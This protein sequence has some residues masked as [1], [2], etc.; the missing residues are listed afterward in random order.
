MGGHW[1]ETSAV[2]RSCI[3]LRRRTPVVARRV[4]VRGRCI[5]RHCGSTRDRSKIDGFGIVKASARAAST[6]LLALIDVSFALTHIG[7]F[8]DTYLVMRHMMRR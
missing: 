1:W 6:S 7:N 5:S 8:S 2:R 3:G 4:I